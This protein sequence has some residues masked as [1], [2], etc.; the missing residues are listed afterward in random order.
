VIDLELVRVSPIVAVAPEFEAALDRFA[1]Y[2]FPH[3]RMAFK[4]DHAL[5]DALDPWRSTKLLEPEVQPV[6]QGSIFNNRVPHTKTPERL[7]SIGL[8]GTGQISRDKSKSLTRHHLLNYSKYISRVRLLFPIHREFRQTTLKMTMKMEMLP[9]ERELNLICR[10]DSHS[11]VSPQ[12][13]AL[14]Q[15]FMLFSQA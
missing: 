2:R 5:V 12:Q 6:N 13:P 9:R 11:M 4:F 3:F 15:E 1:F 10:I 8:P 14:V 7:F